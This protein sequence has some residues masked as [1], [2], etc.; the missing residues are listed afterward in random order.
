MMKKRLMIAL[1]CLVLLVQILPIV[2]MAD[3][4]NAAEVSQ[5]LYY[6]R[7]QLETL[8]NSEALLFAYDNIVAGVDA[9]ATDIEISNEEHKLT[10]DEFL[11]VLDATRRDHT[12]QFWLHNQ[13]S[14]APHP[15]G[16]VVTMYPQYLM[17]KEELELAK[18]AF[19]Q[20]IDSFLDRID[21]AWNEYEKEKALHDMLATKVTYVSTANAHNAYGALVEGLAVCEGY[22]EALQCLLQR[23]GIQSIQ[24]YGYGVNPQT[25]GT[26][27]H[28]WNMVRIDGDYYLTDPT[29]N[30]YDADNT[31]LYAY[32]NQTSAILGEDHI[33]WKVGH[34]AETGEE[35]NCQ[36]FQL[37]NCTATK[38]S[39]FT[40]EGKRISTYSAESIG[41]LLK[42][43]NLSINLFIDSDVAAF[44][45]WYTE[46]VEAIADAAGIT[47]NYRYVVDPMVA[48]REARIYFEI[49][50]HTELIQIPAKAA[51]C[52]TDGNTAYYVCQGKD[53]GKWYADAGAES[54]I[55]NRES[56]KILAAGHDFSV[57]TESNATL[58]K[59]AEKCTEHDTYYFICS[60]CKKISD[61]YTF[62]TDVT[63]SHTYAETWAAD[64]VSNHKRDCINGCGEKLTEAHVDADDVKGC[65][66]CGYTFSIGDL[67]PDNVDGEETTNAIL[68]FIMAN[69]LI[70]GGGG[71]G[72][73]LLTVIILI[74][75]R[76]REG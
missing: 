51:T 6:C 37:P 9:Y 17:T 36:V 49:C 54:E 50:E 8:P 64:G 18:V 69:P 26:E 24:V 55:F 5:D 22:A 68:D 39:Y 14:Y 38:A 72:V 11:M 7:A 41:K 59:R 21:P 75:R 65:D 15:K 71:G 60:V 44:Q 66:V 40:K 2:P 1:C 45:A 25:G 48:G 73:L 13:Y 31:L 23:V 62:Q 3:T 4:A 52:E 67:I 57:K 63:G 12:E 53:C 28:A 58:K 43:N 56:V 74:I 27:N 10:L 33:Q 30:D 46:N 61:T 47:V 35:L 42:E 16:H 20:A 32:F 34:N 76:I 19:E 29:W 70:V